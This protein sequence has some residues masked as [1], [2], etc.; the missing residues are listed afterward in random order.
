MRLCFPRKD[1]VDC[2]FPSQAS[3][4]SSSI[5]QSQNEC[6]ECTCGS[7]GPQHWYLNYLFIEDYQRLQ[8]HRSSNGNYI[9]TAL[10]LTISL[11][12]SLHQLNRPHDS[13]SPAT[14]H[15]LH[16]NKKIQ[17]AATGQAYAEPATRSYFSTCQHN[18]QLSLGSKPHQ[19]LVNASTA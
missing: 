15:S 3:C 18:V 7:E 4:K 1:W 13:F 17:L 6:Q 5:L 8:Q 10:C 14:Y 9:W 12:V 2:I 16:Q 19:R 11:G